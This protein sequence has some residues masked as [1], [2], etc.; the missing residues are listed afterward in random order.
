[1][2]TAGECDLVGLPVVP[3]RESLTVH[4]TVEASVPMKVDPVIRL[5]PSGALESVSRPTYAQVV[6]SMRAIGQPPAPVQGQAEI[7]GVLGD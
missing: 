7:E 2:M 4:G 6:A 3:D 5:S 1:M